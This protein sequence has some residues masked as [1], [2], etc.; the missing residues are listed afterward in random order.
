[1]GARSR[2]V[3]IDCE[4]DR[5]V[6]AR[7]LETAIVIAAALA[8]ILLG[9]E[10]NAAQRPVPPSVFST[11]DSGPN[12]YRALFTVLRQAGAD[13]AQ[14]DRP[15]AL[16]G[17]QTGTLVISDYTADASSNLLNPK[18]DGIALDRFVRNGGRL[19]VLYSA[20]AG[21]NEP[22]VPG[23]L[24]R[25]IATSER[26]AVSLADDRFTVGAD[27]VS[28][29]IDAVF[30]YSERY[31]EPLFANDSGI[32][33]LGYAHGKGE[34]IAITTPALFGNAYLRRA[35]NLAFAYNVI[36]GHGPAAFD[37]YVHGYDDNLSLWAAL[38][39]PVHDAAFIVAGI[40]LLAVAGASVPFAPPIPAEPADERDSSA[41]LDAMAALMRR[42]RARR[43]AVAAFAQNARRL[44]R[45]SE[46]ERVREAA[47]EIEGLAAGDDVSD[48]ALLRAAVLDHRLRRASS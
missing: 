13:V 32:V 1:M 18:K 7:R 15:L 14:F 40:L 33:A 25:Q 4:R 46:D 47:A 45:R 23:G 36:T 28:G 43:V 37:E 29:P 38:P 11:Y 48:E 26:Q 41:F 31:G 22:L 39:Q 35:G 3:P 16:L 12:G 20:T 9:Y 17:P 5:S 42:A 30:P 19:V 21:T 27:R 44:Y 24:G 8:L 34:V 10:R 6:R 2:C